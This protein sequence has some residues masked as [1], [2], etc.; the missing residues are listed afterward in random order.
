MTGVELDTLD[1]AELRALTREVSVYAR[2]APQHKLRLVDSLQSDGQIVSMTGDGVNDAPALKSA[3]IGVAMGITGTEV[4]KEAARMILADDN[5]ATI[6]AAVRQGRVIFQNIQKFLRYLLSS[7][8]GEVLTVFLGVVLA[9]VIGLNEA[10]DGSAVV[11]PLLATQILWINLITDST[12]A[13]AMGIDPEI[14]DV[15][16]RA[17]R[18][19][20]DRAIDARMWRGIV[21]IGLVMALSTLFAIDLFLPG[22]LVA[23][24]QSLDVARTA[25]FTT[26]V[27]AQLFNSLNA[28]SETS[29]AFHG[30]FANKW[31]W[32]AIGLGVALQ[33][34]VVE[35]PF[36]QVAFG[37]ASMDLTQWAACVALG[38]VVLWY[39]ELRKLLLRLN[40]RR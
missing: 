16:A 22:G 24:S 6:V 19:M 14:D 7:N 27:L 31:L 28:R 15:M 37:T 1:D 38:S 5:F 39:D 33:V 26:L 34:A 23:G 20:T 13:L 30:L 32:G 3:D 17:P 8:V 18:K 36:L 12:P 11:L 35:T 25:G 29:S 2:V 4:T 40:D 21:S 9:G 10:S